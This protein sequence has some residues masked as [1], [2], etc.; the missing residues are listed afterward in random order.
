MQDPTRRVNVYFESTCER[1]QLTQRKNK[2][3]TRQ[4]GKSASRTES[5]EAFVTWSSL[6]RSECFRNIV[7]FFFGASISAAYMP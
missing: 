6:V 1:E 3:V 2:I 7:F 4:T 5:S